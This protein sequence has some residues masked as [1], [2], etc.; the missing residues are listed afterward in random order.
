[1]ASPDGMA[2]QS[3]TCP[4]C[5]NVALVPEPASI[6]PPVQAELS[7]RTAI[8]VSG[9]SA[10]SQPPARILWEGVPSWKGSISLYIL[11]GLLLFIGL[12]MCFVLPDI[13]SGMFVMAASSLGILLSEIGRRCT[14]YRVTDQMIQK[15][16]GIF[17]RHLT[18]I[19]VAHLREVRMQQDIMGRL[20]DVGG[21]GFSTSASSNMEI[22]WRSI[23]HP[24]ALQKMIWKLIRN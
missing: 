22:V 18:E 19:P 21:L 14:R 5:G 16:T 20:L 3:D 13:G 7:S 9:Q 23:E 8:E 24:Q 17:S 12:I 2:G 11:C 6:N 10:S 1:M 15:K 4:N